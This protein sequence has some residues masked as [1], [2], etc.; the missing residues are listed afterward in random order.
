M[1]VPDEQR[2]IAR[3]VLRL[4]IQH[5]DELPPARRP[6]VFELAAT[7]LDGAEADDAASCAFH[8]RQAED[9]QRRLFL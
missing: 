8:L 6:E 2:D 7:L 5:L 3:T 1:N 9:F 4:A